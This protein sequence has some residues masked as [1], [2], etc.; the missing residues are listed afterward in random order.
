MKFGMGQGVPRVEDPRLLR[1]R[2]RYTDDI[3]LPGQAHG[4]I[5]Y[6]PHAAARIRS[7]D[8]SEALAMPGVI[9]VLTGADAAADGLGLLPCLVKQMLPLFRPDGSPM[10]DPGR[11]VLAADHV[12]FVGDYVA[13]V[14]AESLAQARDAVEQ[15][16][17]DYEERDAVTATGT[18]QAGGAPAVWDECPDNVCFQQRMGDFETVDAVFAKADHVVRHAIPVTRIAQNP[19]EPRA[20]LGSYDDGDGRYTLHSGTQN[21]HDVRRA[22][23]QEVFGVPETAI[24]VVSP[25]MGGGFGLRGGIAPEMA[26]VLWAAKRVGRPVK[27]TGDRSAAFLTDDHGRDA[28][29]SVELAL[30]KDGTF[31]A[32]KVESIASMGAYLTFFGPFPAFG[33]I[34]TVAG[35]YRTPAIAAD[36]TAVYTNMTP[37]GPYRGAGRPEAS[38]AIELTIDKAARELGIDRVELRRRN[39]IPP[40]AMPFQTGL[41]F[42]YD[43]GEFERNMDRALELADR[44]GFDARRAEAAARGKLRGLG[45][46]NAIE[47]AA[48]LFEEAADIRFDPS[49]GVTV[50]VGTHS[51]GQGHETVFRQ[52]LAD[53]LGLAPEEI[54]YVQG[55]TDQVPHGHGTFGSRS[56]ALAGSALVRASDRLIEKGK[57]IAA[58][59]LEAAADDM[60]FEAGV[61]SIAGT[62]RSMRLQ[63]VARASFAAKDL[64]EGMDTGLAGGA[65]F[66]H[67]APTFPNG[68]HVSEVEIDPDTGTIDI[69]RYL[70]VDDVGT[71]MNPM[72]LKGQMHGGVV[73][74]IGQILFEQVVHDPDSGQLMTGSFMDYTMPRADDLSMIEV[75]THAVPTAV[76]P[77]GVKG[78]GEAGCVGSMPCLMSA[79]LDALGPAGV[80]DLDMPATPERVWRALQDARG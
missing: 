79:I 22:L 53:T 55:D 31:L 4:A 50:V 24:R 35:V 29:M 1:G 45:I 23:A 33:N 34:G 63:D 73:Q 39:I 8:T 6:S 78:A 3:N 18:A 14:I 26:L 72:L 36:I 10:F 38:L 67:P 75:E 17:V 15:I 5:L 21:P 13:F 61:F 80:T 32:L 57:Q 41:M 20:A 48:G 69:L 77:L 30:D 28:L 43:C 44:D 65:T 12:R 54:R 7:I 27:W 66:V 9:A 11:P 76:N 2:G 51:H 19:M 70:L 40:D 56:A 58:H 64:P 71:V 49:G 60:V 62:D 47:Q 16:D 59:K 46:A 74:G 42:V 68:C 25:D 52:L 37:I